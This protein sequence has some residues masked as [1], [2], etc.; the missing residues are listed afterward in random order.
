M[1]KLIQ[2]TSWER[3]A[4]KSKVV[5]VLLVHSVNRQAKIVATKQT[6]QGSIPFRNFSC[7][8]IQLDKPDALKRT[9][10][11]SQINM[12]KA[13]LNMIGRNIL[14]TSTLP[15]FFYAEVANLTWVSSLPTWSLFWFVAVTANWPNKTSTSENKRQLLTDLFLP[16]QT[17]PK[18]DEL[19]C[20]CGNDVEKCI[21]QAILKK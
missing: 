20:A 2:L 5:A 11:I 18:C 4:T 14:V 10:R 21:T 8:P 3:M 6:A 12:H 19:I 15:C 16:N 17:R 7:S 9:T 13:I 1:L